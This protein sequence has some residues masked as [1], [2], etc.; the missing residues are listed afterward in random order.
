MAAAAAPVPAP[1]NPLL[2]NLG[3]IGDWMNVEAERIADEEDTNPSADANDFAV[4]LEMAVNDDFLVNN[5]ALGGQL[6]GP[7]GWEQEIRRLVMIVWGDP[8]MTT[9]QKIENIAGNLRRPQGGRRRR[10][11][12]GAKTEAELY[13]WLAANASKLCEDARPPWWVDQTAG[14]FA[15][16][17]VNVVSVN[18]GDEPPPGWATA[19]T[20]RVKKV[21]ADE[22][23]D[24]D[25]WDCVEFV[26]KV[27]DLKLGGADKE[28]K[29]P[30][31][32]AARTWDEVW[33]YMGE[34]FNRIVAAE[35]ETPASDGGEFGRWLADTIAGEM[36]GIMPDGFTDRVEELSRTHWQRGN[37][38]S[39][40]ESILSNLRPPRRVLAA[41]GKPRDGGH[42]P[43]E[44]FS[45]PVLKVLKAMSINK[46]EVVGTAGD[47]KAM[48]S[49][50]YDLMESV[51]LTAKATKQ[52]QSLVKKAGEVGVVTDIKCGEV[53]EWNLATSDTYNR[54][55]ERDAL[56][57]LHDGGIITGTE[58]KQGQALLRKGLKGLSL[59]TTRQEL[60]FGVLRWTP[61]EVAKGKKTYRG[62]TFTLKECF[63]TGMTKV[64]LVAW[65]GDRY[66]EVSNIIGWT[67]KGKLIIPPVDSLKQDIDRY[68]S[69]GN[70]FKV[71][72]RLYSLAK[73]QGK[74]KTMKDLEKVLNSHLGNI[75][76]VVSDLELLK[77]FP[78]ETKKHRAEGLDEMRDRMAKLYYP[79]YD[80]AT[81][82]ATLLP[83]LW[84][85]LQDATKKELVKLGLV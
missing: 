70:W 83:G 29:P 68:A 4:F 81:N 21:W 63:T 20:R 85:T 49:S 65:V 76:T 37:V 41:E 58:F 33:D 55:K 36:D 47:H 32:A 74:G 72:K 27:A 79:K 18:L 42:R 13:E 51:P 16:F 50:D 38:R 28:N 9:R 73:Q 2:R 15:E 17:L 82:P 39:W 14:G 26:N 25:F 69:E 78:A 24:P 40:L 56:A 10:R 80:H 57:K 23:I 54:E 77:E 64:D 22:K 30:A 60:R 1:P 67:K 3:Q 71:A 19:L 34:Q 53:P 45:S 66:A 12:G 59:V 35:T 62:R 43:D 52:F 6:V 8:K 75:G 7:P 11:R 31:A 48:Y 84:T 5:P 61:A 44:Q 46:I